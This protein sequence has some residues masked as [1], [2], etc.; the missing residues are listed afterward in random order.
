MIY[1]LVLC[2]IFITVGIVLS[3]WEENKQRRER[4]ERL[5]RRVRSNKFRG[6]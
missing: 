3:R 2:F 6:Y 5:L 1:I 4:Y